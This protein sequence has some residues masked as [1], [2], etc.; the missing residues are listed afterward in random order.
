MLRFMEWLGYRFQRAQDRRRALRDDA[1]TRPTWK[2][3][4]LGGEQ[5]WLP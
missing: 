3:A 2:P 5:P 4:P 1:Q